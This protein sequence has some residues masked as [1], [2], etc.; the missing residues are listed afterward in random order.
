MTDDGS[1]MTSSRVHKFLN[2][3]AVD[4]RLLVT[5]VLLLGAIRLGLWLLP[6]QTLR[7]L[8]AKMTRHATDPP[9]QGFGGSAEARREGGRD[10]RYRR[11][12][13]KLIEVSDG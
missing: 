13:R 12:R 2:L 9:P 10:R 8:L 1:R 4:R 11:N 5:A 3:S 7:Q 6:F